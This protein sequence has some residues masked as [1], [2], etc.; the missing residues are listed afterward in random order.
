MPFC[1]PPSALGLC[2]GAREASLCSLLGPRTPLS[3][4]PQRPQAHP[5]SSP[6]DSQDA[7]REQPPAGSARH[8][9]VAISSAVTEL[10]RAATIGSSSS[11]APSATWTHPRPC[12]L[13]PP[14][15]PGKR[16]MMGAEGEG[17]ERYPPP[18]QVH[19]WS[20][21]IPHLNLHLH[22]VPSPAT[23]YS[24]ERLATRPLRSRS[25]LG[26]AGGR[27]CRGCTQNRAAGRAFYSQGTLQP[28]SHPAARGEA[29]I[30]SR[31]TSLPPKLWDLLSSTS[32]V[33]GLLL[34][35]GSRE[36]KPLALGPRAVPPPRSPG[37]V[38]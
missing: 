25:M 35:G 29:G 4:P 12:A 32:S 8:D 26:F 16:G 33:G 36:G 27:H 14:V 9:G 6:P 20:Q 37:T 3:P 28:K 30:P 21:A 2:S 34:K 11:V 22:A 5:R 7:S 17:S 38:W 10:S 23:L 13:L 1:F 18:K 15:S 19:Y 24:T 31:G